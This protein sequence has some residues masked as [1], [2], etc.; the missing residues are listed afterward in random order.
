MDCS[1]LVVKQCAKHQG[2]EADSTFS[3]HKTNTGQFGGF[4]KMVGKPPK[5]MVKIM[6]N[7]I[8][9]GWFGGK[10]QHLRK[11]PFGRKSLTWI[12]PQFGGGIPLLF[13]HNFRWPTGRLAVINSPETRIA[14]LV[15]GWKLLSKAENYTSENTQVF[16][17][18]PVGLPYFRGQNWWSDFST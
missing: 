12:A 5:W 9:N 16:E 3:P 1:N 10:T 6:E 11:H 13:N 8:K 17:R 14:F 4:L 15:F 18:R 7:P 2:G